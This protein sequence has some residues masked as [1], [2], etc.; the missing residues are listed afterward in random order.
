LID[1]DVLVVFSGAAV[2]KHQTR[3]LTE[4]IKGL[5]EMAKP[6]IAQNFFEGHRDK[7]GFAG[8]DDCWLWTAYRHRQGYGVVR[9]GR[10]VHLAHRAAFEAMHGGGSAAGLVV[11]HR[12][13]TPACVNPAHLEAGTQA[14]NVRDRDERKRRVPLNGERH[15][16]AKLTEADIREI[17]SAYVRGSSEFGQY[18]LARRFGVAQSLIGNIVRREG[19]AHVA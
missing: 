14:D 15:G 12:C 13:D 1:S 18:A 6:K 3:A 9:V 7:I 17:R 4:T 16:M 19:W 11:R 8:P 10:K 2:L 5:I